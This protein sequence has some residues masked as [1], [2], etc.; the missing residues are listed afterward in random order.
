MV[1]LRV[2]DE[3][4]RVD[5]YLDASIVWK[6]ASIWC[7]QVCPIKSIHRTGIDIVLFLGGGDINTLTV[8]Y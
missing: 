7:A 4:G 6:I 2:P 1:G 5:R 8:C 3:L